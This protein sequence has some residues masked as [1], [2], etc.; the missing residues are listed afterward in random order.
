MYS[1]TRFNFFFKTSE[2]RQLLC[3]SVMYEIKLSF[4]LIKEHGVGS[5]IGCQK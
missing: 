5:G 1:L 3:I 2:T 4:V